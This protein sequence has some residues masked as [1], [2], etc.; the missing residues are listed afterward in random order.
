VT[1]GIEP[2]S[3]ETG[4]G[5]I[6]RGDALGEHASRVARFVEKP[7]RE[8][9]EELVA[10]GRH[11]WNS[12]IFVWRV[13]SIRAALGRHLPDTD[14]VL[15]EIT[16]RWGED[17][18][19]AEAYGRIEEQSIDYGVLEKAD[20]VAVVPGD[21]G[22]DD[23][24]SWSALMRLWPADADGNVVRGRVIALGSRGNLVAADTRVVALVGVSDLVVV[25]TDDAVLICSAEQAQNVKQVIEELRR[26]GW[27]EHL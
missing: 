18:F 27:V 6:E 22:W 3:A 14:R 21:F 11:L 15:A 4:Y 13:D 2:K 26:R 20:N 23:I 17:S 19:L 24:G 8:R 5:Y 10:T 7:T 9:A 16:A 25:E 1:I 12:G